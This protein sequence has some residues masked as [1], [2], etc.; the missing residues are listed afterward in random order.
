MKTTNQCQTKRAQP[1]K[2][3]KARGPAQR[4]TKEVMAELIARLSQKLETQS[5]RFCAD[6]EVNRALAGARQGISKRT[7]GNRGSK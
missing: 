5:G 7:A 1:R 6:E 4:D 3:G 2:P